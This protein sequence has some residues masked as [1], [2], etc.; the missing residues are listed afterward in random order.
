[1]IEFILKVIMLYDLAIQL[2]HPNNKSFNLMLNYNIKFL[3]IV[4][5]I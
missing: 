2:M 3:S 4:F 1:M 5:V